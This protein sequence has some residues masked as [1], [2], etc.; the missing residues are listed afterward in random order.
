MNTETATLLVVSYREFLRNFQYILG[1]ASRRYSIL[2]ATNTP[3]A[4]RTFKRTKPDL[5][6]A[7]NVLSDDQQLLKDI[8]SLPAGEEVPFIVICSPYNKEVISD[9]GKQGAHIIFPPFR[10]KELLS[11]IQACLEKDDEVRN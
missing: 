7:A 5:V 3:D 8:R 4:L 11:V 6:L 9:L 1:E 2:T 10:P